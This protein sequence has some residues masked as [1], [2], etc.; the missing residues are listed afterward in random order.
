MGGGNGLVKIIN[1]KVWKDNVKAR[2]V[3]EDIMAANVNKAHL[4]H[5]L[6]MALLHSP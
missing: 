4:E 6:P 3:T 1:S 5:C 2:S